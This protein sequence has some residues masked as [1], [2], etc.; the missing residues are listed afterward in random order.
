MALSPFNSNAYGSNY[1][2]QGNPYWNN[3]QGSIYNQPMPQQGNAVVQ[4]TVKPSDPQGQLGLAQSVKDPE[5]NMAAVG[6][7]ALTGA[8]IGTEILPG[9]GSLIGAAAGGL[10][11]AFAKEGGT[12]NTP[13]VNVEK[14]ELRLKRAGSGYIVV[15][16]YNDKPKHPKQGVHP[17]GNEIIDQGDIII[18]AD[19]RNDTLAMLKNQDWKSL[20]GL[21]NGLPKNGIKLEDGVS[22]YNPYGAT[23]YAGAPYAP[24]Y[25]GYQTQGGDVQDVSG[26]T[27]GDM[28]NPF[29]T[30]TNANPDGSANT[31][32]NPY[33]PNGAPNLTSQYA[34]AGIYNSIPGIGLGALQTYLGLQG[35]NNAGNMPNYGI[36]PELQNAYN[37]SQANARHGFSPAERI[38]YQQEIAHQQNTARQQAL[39]IGGGQ[40]SG[41]I[42]GVL[43]GQRLTAANQFAG[44]DAAL[45][46]QNQMYGDNLAQQIQA[47]K[48]KATQ[49]NINLW[50]RKQQ[51]YG[52]QLNAGAQ[53]LTSFLGTVGSLSSL[54]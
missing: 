54:I 37:T 52:Q 34:R 39:D 20:D 3:Q 30:I 53:N 51:A 33:N 22:S 26:L 15:D 48:D 10:Y 45:K 25:T 17:A 2:Q 32:L 29:G 36:S 49:E 38:A 40:L 21:I 23:T 18:P 12:M 7:D 6:K 11:G 47:Q 31:N 9:W 44:Q 42:N 19:K 24:D 4:Q 41:T 50:N 14:N 35:L 46:R 1:M 13:Y 27:Q 43:N 5:S 16:D 28:A 8:A